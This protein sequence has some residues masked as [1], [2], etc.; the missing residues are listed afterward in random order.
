MVEEMAEDLGTYPE[1]LSVRKFN[2]LF[3]KANVKR[4]PFKKQW[5]DDEGKRRWTS[6]DDA[7][8]Y[9]KAINYNGQIYTGI[10]KEDAW[11]ETAYWDRG[12]HIINRTGDFCVVIDDRFKPMVY[13]S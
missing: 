8:D 9:L 12:Y 2:K 1:W 6:L 13:T 11:E 3:K 4:F 10:H 7:Y 5:F